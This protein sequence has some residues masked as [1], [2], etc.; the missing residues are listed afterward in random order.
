MYVYPVAIYTRSKLKAGQAAREFVKNRTK[1]CK[2][3]NLMH[4]YTISYQSSA[5]ISYSGVIM[6]VERVQYNILI[7]S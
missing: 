4:M 7:V 1:A 5:G 2:N 6:P 3:L